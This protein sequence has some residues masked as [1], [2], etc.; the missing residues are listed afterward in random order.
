LTGTGSDNRTALGA[1]NIT[2]VAGGMARRR[3]T[4]TTFG[5][6]DTV[7]MTIRPQNLPSMS[8]AGLAAL[9]TVI[10]LGAGYA[11]RKRWS[12]GS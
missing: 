7:T 3:P 2:L 8:P 4:N 12:R 6:V 5:S 10:L 1:G 11:S 9:A